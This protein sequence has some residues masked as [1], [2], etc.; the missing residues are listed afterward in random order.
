MI[1]NAPWVRYLYYFCT[2]GNNLKLKEINVICT[3]EIVNLSAFDILNYPIL[4][5]DNITSANLSTF[6]ILN[7]P[8]LGEFLRIRIQT[9]SQTNCLQQRGGDFW[10][11]VLK[12]LNTTGSS[13]S[14]MVDHKNGTYSVDLY[15]GW[16]GEVAVHIILVHPSI[17]TQFLD[18]VTDISDFS[19]LY[20]NGTFSKD[21]PISSWIKILTKKQ[22]ATSLCYMMYHG[23]NSW[24]DKCAY[25][26]ERTLGNNTA[27]VCDKPDNGLACDNLVSYTTNGH[28]LEETFRNISC[29][30]GILWLF[31]RKYYLQR[32]INGPT[33]IKV[34]TNNNRDSQQL[35]TSTGSNI[36]EEGHTQITFTRNVSTP[37]VMT[38]SCNNPG[39][40]YWSGQKWNAICYT[41]KQW[42]HVTDVGEC[43]RNKNI[44][45]LGDS[46]TRQWFVTL[47]HLLRAKYSSSSILQS[48]RRYRRYII[49]YNFNLT[50][51]F[52]PHQMGSRVVPIKNEKFEVEMLDNLRDSR[53]NYIV[54]ISPWAHFAQWWLPAYR[55]RVRLIR[56]AILRF[57]HRCPDAPVILKSPHVRDHGTEVLKQL[58]Y[59]DYI[60]F[61]IKTIMEEMLNI[62]G[63]YYIDVWNMNLAYPAKKSVH[64]PETVVRQEELEAFA[65]AQIKNQSHCTNL[66]LYIVICK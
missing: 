23:P 3:D 39:I 24:K 41:T 15:V 17:A 29:K 34:Q 58:M 2:T 4:D 31:E 28:L 18:R 49:E 65:E 30:S 35:P 57:K 9:R 43:F 45:F 7:Q 14:P 44:Y 60:L 33:I 32:V 62:D 5:K 56:E 61:K 8:I 25:T 52:Y 40:G 55:D 59:S 27:W 22:H 13:S 21:I 6:D 1:G 12:A 50:F 16:S 10:F 37:G 47:L 38:T 51:Q 11:A 19:R 42:N 36:Q 64:M 53:C 48:Y 63:V 20:W 54:T 46:T 66:S 26:S